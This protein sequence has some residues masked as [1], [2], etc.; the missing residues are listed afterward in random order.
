MTTRSVTTCDFCGRED[1]QPHG[2]GKLVIGSITN[3]TVSVPTASGSSS[4]ICPT[5]IAKVKGW[6]GAAA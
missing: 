1:E 2:W 6:K 5:C 3:G 4:D